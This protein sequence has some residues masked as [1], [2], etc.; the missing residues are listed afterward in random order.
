[1]AVMVN[2]PQRDSENVPAPTPGAKRARPLF[3]PPIV[4]RALGDAFRK[5]DPRV[6]AKNPVMF[7]VWVGSVVTTVLF[8]QDLI[9]HVGGWE[10]AFVG[11]VALWLWFTVLFAGFAEAI[12]EGRGKAQADELRKTR[13]TTLAKKWRKGGQIENVPAPSLRKG[14]VVLCE[15]GRHHSQRRHCGGRHCQR[16]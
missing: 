10:T 14:D 9:R 16:G 13:S 12:A 11:Q 15:V 1:M 6:Q 8:G 5:L 3:D 2:E 7:V 4:R